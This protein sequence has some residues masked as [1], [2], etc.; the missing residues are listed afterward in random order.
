MTT[1]FHVRIEYPDQ[2]YEDFQVQAEDR[3]SAQMK[4]EDKVIHNR[5]LA[6]QTRFDWH[7]MVAF[8]PK[9]VMTVLGKPYLWSAA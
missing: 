8:V 9:E 2:T 5:G 4:A 6:F 1:N 3:I 7:G